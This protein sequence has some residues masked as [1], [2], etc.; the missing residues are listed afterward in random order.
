MSTN[1]LTHSCFIPG[2]S[3]SFTCCGRKPLGPPA[4]PVG[5]LVI[6]FATMS[7]STWRA[8]PASTLRRNVRPTRSS[9]RANGCFARIS[10]ATA[11]VTSTGGSETRLAAAFPS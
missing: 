7:S 10:L 8:A 2:S 9:S 1:C 6:A 4:E 3:A 11:A 5:K